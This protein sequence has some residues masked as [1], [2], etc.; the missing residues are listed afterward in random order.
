MAAVLRRGSAVIPLVEPFQQLD[1]PLQGT[2]PPGA[3]RSVLAQREVFGYPE[4]YALPDVLVMA[5]ATPA[6]RAFFSGLLH[7]YQPEEQALLTVRGRLN[8]IVDYTT[9]QPLSYA[10]CQIL[11]PMW[12]G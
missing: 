6:R 11:C 5:F 2:H 9:G 1:Q 4:E 12:D 7:G 8:P 10:N 3:E